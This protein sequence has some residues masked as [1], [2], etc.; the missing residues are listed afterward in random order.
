MR[1]LEGIF[2]WI[3]I[4]FYV[5]GFLLF[6]IG[7]IFKKERVSKWGWVAGVVGFI[8]HN[9]TIVVRWIESGHP[10][11]YGTYEHF[12]AQAWFLMVI[13]ISV[14]AM[15]RQMRRIGA[16]ILPLCVLLL[17]YGIMSTGKE[18]VP[19][20]PPYQSL[21]L[22]VHAGMSW[23][24]YGAFFISAVMAGL[25]LIKKR[26]I[27]DEGLPY[28]DE[29]DRLIF[30]M[31]IFGFVNLTIE[32]GAGALWAYGLWGR[33]WG[34]DPI[35]TWTLITW[36]IYGLNI[37]LRVSY[38]WKGAKA[39]WLAIVSLISVIITLGGLGFVGGLHTTL[40]S[41]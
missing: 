34:W 16:G 24:A 28:L 32:M 3:G 6:F 14:G 31:I 13:F 22:W 41:E 1:I 36:I 37:H 29:L 12:L 2:L 11:F 25:Y 10:P 7:L 21:W 26:G 20:P 5:I 15:S 38:G 8:S 39:A 23:F 35:E 33:Y 17:G 4:V 27:L 40:L 9:L 18:P 30:G 19:L